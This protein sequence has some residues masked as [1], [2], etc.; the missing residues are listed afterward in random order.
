MGVRATNDDIELQ[1]LMKQEDQ[2]QSV[3]TLS[4]LCKDV[5]GVEDGNLSI[6]ELLE[7]WD[8]V[9]SFKQCLQFMDVTRND[10]PVLWDIMDADGDGKVTYTEFVH[11]LH[12][13]KCADTRKLLFQ[14]QHYSHEIVF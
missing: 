13:L 5:D 11:A 9:P 7:A 10:L 8:S 6:E 14:T 1:K 2:K 4:R 3:R 12:E